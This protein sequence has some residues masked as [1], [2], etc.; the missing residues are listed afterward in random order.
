MIDFLKQLIT[1]FMTLHLNWW[2]AL[3]F[4]SFIIF[5]IMLVISSPIRDFIGNVIL[6]FLKRKR[7]CIDC[8]K[9]LFAKREK[10]D[11]SRDKHYKEIEYEEDNI[12][13]HQ[14]NF[15]EQKLEE[16]EL[17]LIQMMNERIKELKLEHD[18]EGEVLNYRMFWGLVRDALFFRMRD[19]MRRSFKENGFYNMSGQLFSIFVKEKSRVLHTILRNHIIN[20]YPNNQCLISM[21]K[22][23]TFIN[24]V[25]ER[26]FEDMIFSVYEESKRI[27]RQCMQNILDIKNRIEMDTLKFQQEIDEFIKE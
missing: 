15:A 18:I 16:I 3:I 13:K 20:L 22:V 6:K 17:I 23:L 21:E 4:L 26:D 8:S 2:Q 12:L 5:A 10:L 7:L 25:F 27:K 19:E 1:W 24:G 11:A 9:I 14:M